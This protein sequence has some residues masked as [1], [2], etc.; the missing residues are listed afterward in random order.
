MGIFGASP[1]PARDLTSEVT[2]LDYLP[3]LP[4]NF[5]VPNDPNMLFYLQRSTNANTIVYAADMIAPGQINPDTPVE[6]YWRRYAEQGQRR[7]LH[8]LERVLAFGVNAKPVA[9]HA[10]TF[11]ADIAGYSERQFS[12]EIDKSGNPEAVGKIGDRNARMVAAYIQVDE[13]GLIPSV[14]YC[15]IYGVDQTTG[16][17]L[18]EHLVPKTD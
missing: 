14:V 16:Q 7:Q 2:E 4:G 13:H 17:V 9:G 11:N 5:P 1:E 3:P 18:K 15:D 12:V 8:F 10:N 6:V